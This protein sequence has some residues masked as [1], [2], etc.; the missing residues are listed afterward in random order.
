MKTYLIVGASSG[1]GRYIA[2]KLAAVGHRI[3]T[4]QRRPAEGI[5]GAIHFEFDVTNPNASIPAIE[6]LDGIVYCPGTINLKPFHRIT[7]SEL[8]EEFEINFFGAFRTIQKCL[9]A[10]KKS[11]S[12]SVV[13]FSTVAVQTGMPFH[14]G[15]ASA[16][17]AIEG[18]TKSLAAELAPAIRVNAIAPSLT[19]TPL[20]SKLLNTEAKQESARQRHPLKRYGTPSDIGNAALWLLSEQ[21]AWVTGQIFHIDGGMS[22]LKI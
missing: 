18:L 17:G 21:S 22:T 6:N 7:E 3:Y 11:E 12:A 13:L 19:D 10:L 16:K 5:Q 9:P 2:E 1:I 8:K 20:A 14:A 15:I 4:G